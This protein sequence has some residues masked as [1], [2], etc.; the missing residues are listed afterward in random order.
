MQ[1]ALFGGRANVKVVEKTGQV[2]QGGE[3]DTFGDCGD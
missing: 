2:Q 3:G 1:C